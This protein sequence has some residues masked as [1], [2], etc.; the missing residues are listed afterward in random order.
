MAVLAAWAEASARAAV[1]EVIPD[2]T[3]NLPFFE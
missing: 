1:T 3:S 2:A